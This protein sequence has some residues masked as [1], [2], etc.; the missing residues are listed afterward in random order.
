ME[1]H[2]QNWVLFLKVLKF[3]WNMSSLPWQ[4]AWY[5]VRKRHGLSFSFFLIFF[6][7][8]VG[9]HCGIYKTSYN[10]S[11]IS[12]LNSPP[13]PF[14][15]YPLLPPFLEYFQQ[16][17]LFHLP[18]CVHSICTIFTLPHPFPISSSLQLVPTTPGRTCSALLFFNFVKEKKMTVLFV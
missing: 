2:K 17:S 3:S 6:L 11:N 18:I 1:V 14:S 16:V 7:C 10:V 4:D 15:F 8:W 5:F 13:P 9:V 12:H